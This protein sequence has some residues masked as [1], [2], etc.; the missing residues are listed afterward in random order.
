M[1]YC[2]ILYP[3]YM[4]QGYC[5]GL[6]YHSLPSLHGTWTLLW[7]IVAFFIQHTCYMDIAMVYCSILYPAYILHGHY[8][9]LL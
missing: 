5:Y 2:S 6:L 3:A 4:L 1:V 8:Y 7:F 9:G